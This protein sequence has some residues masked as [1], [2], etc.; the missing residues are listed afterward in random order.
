YNPSSGAALCGALILPVNAGAFNPRMPARRS[1]N[2]ALIPEEAGLTW[3]RWILR[4]PVLL[5]V[6]ALSG[7]LGQRGEL[8]PSVDRAQERQQRG[9]LAGAADVF[10]ELAQQNSGADGSAYALQAAHAWIAARRPDDAARALAM[11]QPP[12]T[13]AQTFDRQMLDVQ[14]L[15]GRG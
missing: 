8:P 13:P 10:E 11:A 12:L 14:I 1:R 5:V 9:D 2:S 7:C 4:L 3:R 15:L 6:V